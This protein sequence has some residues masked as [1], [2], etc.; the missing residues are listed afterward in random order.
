MS[1]AVGVLLCCHVT[2]ELEWL[3]GKELEV[4]EIAWSQLYVETGQGIGSCMV[5]GFVQ[6]GVEMGLL[7][8]MG[9][10]LGRCG[11]GLLQVIC[12]VQR[13]EKLGYQV[14]QTDAK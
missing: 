4:Q 13:M 1:A 10:G 14:G 6:L 8:D 3:L 9:K 5:L 11:V 7:G 2:V 12:L